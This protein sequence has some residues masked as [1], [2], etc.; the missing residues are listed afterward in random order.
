MLRVP[1]ARVSDLIPFYFAAQ[2]NK[3]GRD[4]KGTVGS[5]SKTGETRAEGARERFDSFL[6]FAAGEK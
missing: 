6:F 3:K 2:Q 4:H 5:L 1:K